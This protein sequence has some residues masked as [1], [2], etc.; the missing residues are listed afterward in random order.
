MKRTSFS[1]PHILWDLVEILHDEILLARGRILLE[2]F[3]D[4]RYAKPEG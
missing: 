3:K 4:C 2:F 1:T